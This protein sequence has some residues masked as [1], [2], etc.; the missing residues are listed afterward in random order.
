[1]LIETIAGHL[2]DRRRFEGDTLSLP[3][4]VSRSGVRRATPGALQKTRLRLVPTRKLPL[5]VPRNPMRIRMVEGA[6][7]AAALGTA[8]FIWWSAH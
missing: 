7:V 4:I 3:R 2:P 8:L 1:M 5:T 6:Y